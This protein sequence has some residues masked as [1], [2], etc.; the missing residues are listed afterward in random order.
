MFYDQTGFTAAV[1]ELRWSLKQNPKFWHAAVLYVDPLCAKVV[2]P[3]RN[4]FK[5]IILDHELPPEVQAFRKWN[6]KGWWAYQGAKRFG[7]I[8]YCDFD[9]FVRRMPDTALARELETGPRFLYIPGYKRPNKVV[10]CG[11][12]FYDQNCDWERYLPLIF[13]K[14]KCDERAWTETTGITHETFRASRL[15]MNPHIVNWDWVLENPD[16]RNTPYII[17]GISSISGGRRILRQIG[18]SEREIHFKN[19]FKEELAYHWQGIKR[20]FP[21]PKSKC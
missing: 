13:N 11:C 4:C 15:H 9:I 7:R 12:A 6:C 8:L 16:Q 2:A 20:Q 18:Y 10:G 17:H 19:T 3:F 21:Y 14:W 5:E 1:A